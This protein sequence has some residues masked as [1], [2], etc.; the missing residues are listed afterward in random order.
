MWLINEAMG[1]HWYPKK[2]KMV[3]NPEPNGFTVHPD[4]GTPMAWRGDPYY[5]ELKR[6]AVQA[7]PH[8][9]QINVAYSDK[10][11]IAI[12]PDEDVDLGIVTDDDRLVMSEVRTRTGTRL[13]V[14]KVRYDDPRIKGQQPGVPIKVPRK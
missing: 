6:M 10:R 4:P 2:A 14:E 12:L 8:L 5:S 13:I 1:D 9:G 3:V 11:T 7:A